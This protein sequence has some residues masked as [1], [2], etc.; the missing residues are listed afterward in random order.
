[1]VVAAVLSVTTLAVAAAETGSLL[2]SVVQRGATATDVVLPTG[3]D[4]ASTAGD[5]Q[6]LDDPRLDALQCLP[7]SCEA[8]RL[9]LRDEAVHIAVEDGWLAVLDGRVLRMLPAG[10]DDVAATTDP[11]SAVQDQPP[12]ARA[13][14][15]PPAPG[16]T[17]ISN[18]DMSSITIDGGEGR[19]LPPPTQLTVAAGGRAL[20][21]WPDRLVAVDPDGQVWTRESEGPGLVRA[22]IR[23]DHVVTV[24]RAAPPGAGAPDGV[25]DIRTVTAYDLVDGQVLWERTDLHP[26]EFI[27]AGLVATNADGA[28]EVVRTDD[29]STRWRRQTTGEERIQTSPGPWLV[30][31]DRDGAVLLDTHTGEE[32]AAR[33][34]GRLVTPLQPVGDLYLAVWAIDQAFDGS[35]PHAA[36]VALD[37]GGRER[38]RVTLDS[39][40]RGADLSAA[41]PWVSGTVAVYTPSP[42][43]GHWTMYHAATGEP[44]PL[45]DAALPSLPPGEAVGRTFVD[46]DAPGRLIRRSGTDVAILSLEGAAIVRGENVDVV[47]VDP[48]VVSSNRH[49]L[50]VRPVSVSSGRGLG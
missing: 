47:S 8:W 35:G 3:G 11:S 12:D 13:D 27:D 19:D 20:L 49:L 44:A 4:P 10:A 34:E 24:S 23:G 40:L 50:G 6:V 17:R 14:A 16:R 30:A 31:S 46:A 43:P 29:G 33:A 41:I 25:V 38:W 7:R 18:F 28:L 32:V 5:G 22:T 26:L 42:S 37:V 1:M 2:S 15:S 45:R 48:L 39:V 9:A 36:L 21:M